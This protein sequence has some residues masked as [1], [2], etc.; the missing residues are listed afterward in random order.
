VRGMTE[1]Y[2]KS[3]AGK[4]GEATVDYSTEHGQQMLDDARAE[5]QVSRILC[6]SGNPLIFTF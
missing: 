1:E 3:A 2:L 4:A 5:A 6:I